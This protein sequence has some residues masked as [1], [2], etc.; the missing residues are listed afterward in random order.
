MGYP[1]GKKITTST[2]YC[3]TNICKHLSLHQ[4]KNMFLSDIQYTER[5]VNILSTIANN[6]AFHYFSLFQQRK[7]KMELII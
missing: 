4:T 2:E 1:T 3:P 7:I 6:M 5:I